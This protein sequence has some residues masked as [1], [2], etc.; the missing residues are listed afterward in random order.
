[1]AQVKFGITWMTY[2][3]QIIDLPKWINPDDEI[4]V[5]DYIESVWETIPLPAG[6][7]ISCSDNLDYENIEVII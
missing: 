2:G 6:S 7:Y 1:M 5:I 3:E 4:G